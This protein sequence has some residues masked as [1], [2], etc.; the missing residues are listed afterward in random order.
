LA[1]QT[2]LLDGQVSHAASNPPAGALTTYRQATDLLEGS[3]LPA[4]RRLADLNARSLDRTN[5]AQRGTTLVAR[6]WVAGSGTVLL[7]LLLI[8]HVYLARRFRRII[9]PSLATATLLAAVLTIWGV[10]LLTHEADHLRVAKEEWR[11]P[12]PRRPH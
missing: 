3:L 11:R 8:L 2:I 10:V 9:N 7:A 12:R 1:A 4:A 6:T 5:Q